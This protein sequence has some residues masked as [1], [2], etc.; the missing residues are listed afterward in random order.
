MTNENLKKL[1]MIASNCA[2]EKVQRDMLADI[3]EEEEKYK[4]HDLRKDKSDLPDAKGIYLVVSGYKRPT[5]LRTRYFD[6]KK[7]SYDLRESVEFLY[8]AI[9]WIG[10]E[11]FEDGDEE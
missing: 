7:F 5:D 2:L 1:K 6:G 8:S 11:P 10:I 3:I 9:A 4:W